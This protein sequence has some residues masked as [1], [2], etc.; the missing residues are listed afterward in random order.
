MYTGFFKMLEDI[1]N[2]QNTISKTCYKTH[3]TSKMIIENA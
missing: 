1:K 2:L 3:Q